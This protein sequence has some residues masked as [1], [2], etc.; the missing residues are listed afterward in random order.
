MFCFPVAKS[1]YEQCEGRSHVTG[2]FAFFIRLL[3]FIGLKMKKWYAEK[4][5]NDRKDQIPCKK[6][7]G[8]TV[9]RID[10]YEER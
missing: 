2:G 8:I 4:R 9:E 7:Y 10:S 6:T 3:Q 1:V 5:R